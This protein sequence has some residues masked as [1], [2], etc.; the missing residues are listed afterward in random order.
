[1]PLWL[2]VLNAIVGLGVIKVLLD[3]YCP[4]L[5]QLVQWAITIAVLL[6]VVVGSQEYVRY[7][8]RPRHLTEAER[9]RLTAAFSKSKFAFPQITVGFAAGDGEAAAYALEF[10]DEFRHAG[11]KVAGPRLIFVES[12]NS[13]GLMVVVRDIYHPPPLAELFAGRLDEA[14]MKFRPGNMETLG[15]N[16]F[17]FVVGSRAQ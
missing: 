16:D 1:M 17:E 6:V 15:P 2:I 12:A 11:F 13:A 4:R 3:R 5:P 8:H 14:H 7:L 9:E 10:V